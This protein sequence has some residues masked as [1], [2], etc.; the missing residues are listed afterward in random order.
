M[1]LCIFSEIYCYAPE[2]IANGY[3]EYN[4]NKGRIP[5]NGTARYTCDEGFY[6]SGKPTIRCQRWEQWDFASPICK[7]RVTENVGNTKYRPVTESWRQT[8]GN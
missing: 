2:E 7:P 4:L 1:L 3:V 8:N 6:L 5:Y